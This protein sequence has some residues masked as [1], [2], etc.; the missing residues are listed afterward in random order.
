MHD[1]QPVARTRKRPIPKGG[2]KI[3]EDLA[4]KGSREIDIAM[5]L[6]VSESTWRRLRKNDPKVEA[7]FQRGRGRLRQLLIGAL[8]QPPPGKG[9]S[10]SERNSSQQ[11]SHRGACLLWNNLI[12]D[13]TAQAGQGATMNVQIN[14]PAPMPLAEYRARAITPPKEPTDE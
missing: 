10:I 2:L 12:G 5:A 3:I 11:L 14:I 13:E 6:T 8:L 9:T 1:D 4:A 7:A